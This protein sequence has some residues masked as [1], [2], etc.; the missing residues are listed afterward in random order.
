MEDIFEPVSW[1]LM[2][3]STVVEIKTKHDEVIIGI[4]TF[5][6]IYSHL[7]TQRSLGILKLD[8]TGH[9]LTF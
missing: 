8:W 1:T 9:F 4:M 7:F 2:D 6:A 5:L 3:K